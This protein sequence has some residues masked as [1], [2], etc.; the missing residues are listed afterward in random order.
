MMQFLASF[1]WDPDRIFVRVP[2]LNFPIYWY[3]V[4]FGIGFAIEYLFLKKFV[5][6]Y[7]KRSTF[8]FEQNQQHLE[9]F[10]THCVTILTLCS[11]LG[12]RLGY[13]LFYGWPYYRE[14][15]QD[16]VKIW[17]G[18]LASHGASI[19]LLAGLCLLCLSYRRKE[20]SLTF[21]TLLDML[22]IPVGFTGACIRLGNF[23]NQ[24]ITGTPTS[25]PWGVEFLH[26]LDGWGGI[27]HPVQLYEACF[28]L[29]LGCGMLLLARRFKH[30]IGTGLFISVLFMVMFT[31]RFF[32]EFLKVPQGEVMA[33]DAFLRMGQ[34]LSL[35]FILVGVILFIRYCKKV[36]HGKFSAS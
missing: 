7:L 17:E 21:L 26:P 2:Y 30:H 19:G 13:V 10:M 36:K 20:P 1:V 35:P 16:I 33:Q 32:I 9:K 27:V 22:A 18:G 24:E 25:L 28:Y 3:G 11:V 23:F 4:L 15:P 6:P 14:H 12:G 5:A 31:F 34:V 8:T 29:L